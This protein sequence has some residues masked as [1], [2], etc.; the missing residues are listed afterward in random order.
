MI[1]RMGP[2]TRWYV[3]T[4]VFL[5]RPPRD[6]VGAVQEDLT[7]IRAGDAEEAY[8]RALEVGQGVGGFGKDL[9][10]ASGDVLIRLGLGSYVDIDEQ[11]EEY[12]GAVPPNLVHPAVADE[13]QTFHFLGL[14]DLVEVRG[15][16]GHGTELA[17]KQ[18]TLRENEDLPALTP[19]ETPMF[20][21][22]AGPAFTGEAKT[23]RETELLRNYKWY[24]AD[25]IE[26]EKED[27]ECGVTGVV[28]RTVLISADT[29]GEAASKAKLAITLEKESGVVFVEAISL[30]ESHLTDDWCELRS[31]LVDLTTTELAARIPTKSK[32]AVFHQTGLGRN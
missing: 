20:L 27:V 25:I 18:R 16:L 28:E 30:V 10:E 6:G 2:R 9:L 12:S 14:R 22:P 23:A 11:S 31:S 4:L 8:Q 26:I 29:P 24:L 19:K 13:Y 32:L 17:K 21:S 1:R 3:A 15:D 7:L 5:I